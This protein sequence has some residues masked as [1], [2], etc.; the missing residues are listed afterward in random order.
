MISELHRP[1]GAYT[2]ASIEPYE[3]LSSLSATK[4]VL[5]TALKS[6]FHFSKNTFRAFLL[7]EKWE[8]RK[9]GSI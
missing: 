3:A 2:G 9:V 5:G 8:V 7:A 4:T 6:T 1:I